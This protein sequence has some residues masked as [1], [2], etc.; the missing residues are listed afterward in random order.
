MRKTHF[1]EWIKYTIKNIVEIIKDLINPN[2]RIKFNNQVN[3]GN[4]IYYWADTQKLEN[5]GFKANKNLKKTYHIREFSESYSIFSWLLHT[6][7]DTFGNL[8]KTFV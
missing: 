6:I 1:Y 3:I 2:I 5:Y 4:P 7:N 8:L